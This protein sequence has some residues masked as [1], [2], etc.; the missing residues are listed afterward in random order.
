MRR[1]RGDVR[2]LGWVHIEDARNVALEKTAGA[3]ATLP[4]GLVLV[5]GYGEFVIA[6]AGR[7]V[8]LPNLPL[9]QVD[10]LPLPAEG[11]TELPGT[12]WV[13]ETQVLNQMP[14][15]SDRWTAVL[16]Y[17]MCRGERH[18]R[19]RRPGDRFQPAGMQGHTR[20]LHDF[21]IDEKIQRAVR[22]L[23]PLLIVGDRIAWVCGLRIDERA[24]VTPLTREFWR[25]TL[26]KKE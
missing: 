11:T 5:V 16:D 6:D 25:V 3:E 1:L 24:Q 20:S 22:A 18:L 19:R 10:N 26:R 9:L 15:V 2:N 12:G 23:M 7:G 21:M 13:V 14:E 8:P 4:N 17:A